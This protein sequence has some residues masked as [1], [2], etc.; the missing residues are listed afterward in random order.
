M[1]DELA[2]DEAPS[3]TSSNSL[4][5]EFRNDGELL[6]RDWEK[7]FKTPIVTDPQMHVA[8]PRPWHSAENKLG[9][10]RNFEIPPTF[11]SAGT[12]LESEA[13][14]IDRYLK[15]EVSAEPISRNLKQD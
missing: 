12:G 4:R 7:K 11:Y 1:H 15:L 3:G 8:G 5:N 14:A 9:A 6:I 13:E 10:E 2:R